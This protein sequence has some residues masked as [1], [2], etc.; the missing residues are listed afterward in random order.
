MD[1]IKKLEDAERKAFASG[2]GTIVIDAVEEIDEKI[3]ERVMQI[4]RVN[5]ILEE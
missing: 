4:E 3:I 2:D 5:E 1:R